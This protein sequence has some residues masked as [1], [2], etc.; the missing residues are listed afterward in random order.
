MLAGAVLLVAMVLVELRVEDPMV[1]LRLLGDRM[2]RSSNLM[3]LIGFTSFF[4]ILY[5]VPLYYQNAR[6]LSALQSGLSTFPEAIGVMVGAQVVGRVL[7][8]KFGP[9]RLMA[10][11]LSGVAVCTALMSLCG[12]HTS[13]WWMRLLMFALGYCITHL[14]VSMQAAAMATITPAATGRASMVFNANRQLGGAVGVALLS[15]VLSAVGPVRHLAGRVVPHLAAYHYAFLTASI[16]AVGGVILAL[17]TVHDEDAASTRP[18]HTRRGPTSTRTRWL[19][20]R[21]TPANRSASISARS[22]LTSQRPSAGPRIWAGGTA[23]ASS[24]APVFSAAW[25]LCT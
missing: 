16:A 11:G 1:D 17:A 5:L 6:G 9:R 19:T 10:G 3:V 13:L 18:A 4:G 8:P 22:A 25:R 12:A 14:M 20:G 2:F 23:P 7:Y 15:S 21:G 24:A